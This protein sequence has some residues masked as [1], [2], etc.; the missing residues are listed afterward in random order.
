MWAVPKKTQVGSIAQSPAL[1]EY[2]SATVQPDSSS[3]NWEQSYPTMN[4]H[5]PFLRRDAPT[6]HFQHY[7]HLAL[8]QIRSQ[9]NRTRSS[10]E[11]RRVDIL[12]VPS[13]QTRMVS[14]NRAALFYQTTPPRLI[15][16]LCSLFEWLASCSAVSTGFRRAA[17]FFPWSGQRAQPT[18]QTQPSEWIYVVKDFILLHQLRAVPPFSSS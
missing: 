9:P 1:N 6:L 8:L 11:I 5:H 4:S 2:P 15:S 14:L 12:H 17:V 3:P 7:M 16:G 13:S 18:S 10:M